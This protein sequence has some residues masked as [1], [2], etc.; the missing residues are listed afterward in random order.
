MFSFVREVKSITGG[1]GILD[2]RTEDEKE[3]EEAV[4]VSQKR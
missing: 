4:V 1:S 2:Y 3:R